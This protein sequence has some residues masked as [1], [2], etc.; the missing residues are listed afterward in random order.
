MSLP[1]TCP[2]LCARVCVRA[3]PPAVLAPHR[4]ACCVL[5]AACVRACVR[6]CSF[7]PEVIAVLEDSI[8]R[9]KGDISLLE[10]RLSR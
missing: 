9:K 1:L 10:H 7:D 6:V 8:E 2:V 5:R 3:Y 4:R